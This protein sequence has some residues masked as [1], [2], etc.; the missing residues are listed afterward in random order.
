MGIPSPPWWGWVAVT[1]TW[2]LLVFYIQNASIN[3][4]ERRV[5]ST[6]Q[7]FYLWFYERASS[8]GGI[9]LAVFGVASSTGEHTFNF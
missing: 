8:I 5:M 4:N 1:V 3:V 6:V 7:Q 2:I 9:L